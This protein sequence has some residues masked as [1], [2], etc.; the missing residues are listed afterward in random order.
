[1][2]LL[3]FY[4]RSIRNYDFLLRAL[5]RSFTVLSD[6]ENRLAKDVANFA[7]ILAEVI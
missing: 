5:N 6:C 2:T 3:T 4:K 1:M 7:I